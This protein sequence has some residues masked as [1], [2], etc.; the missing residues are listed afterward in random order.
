M[1]TPGN[2][3]YGNFSLNPKSD[4][5]YCIVLHRDNDN[6]NQCVVTTFTTSKSRSVL[7]PKHG[8]NELVTHGGEK[9]LSHVFK[10]GVVVGTTAKN[11]P[12][13]FPKDSTIV[14]DYGI[15]GW[16]MDKLQSIAGLELKCTLNGAEFGD[17]LYTLL[18]SEKLG[19]KYQHIIEEAL[20]KLYNS[21]CP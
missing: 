12:F 4:Y 14:P 3:L 2:V 13:S 6:P 8:R 16:T 15:N 7:N 21:T 1:L 17:M 20:D 5:K 19:K 18:K 11:E 10:A 9:L